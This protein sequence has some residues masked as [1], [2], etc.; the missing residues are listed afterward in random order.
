MTVM[1]I[2]YPLEQPKEVA[3]MSVDALLQASERTPFANIVFTS[4]KTQ[5]LM[6]VRH[7][8]PRWL[9]ARLQKACI[10]SSL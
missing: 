8:L 3:R 10:A 1:G 5:F 2:P 6:L 9:M 7:L 4:R